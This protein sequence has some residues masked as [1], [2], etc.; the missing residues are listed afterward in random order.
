MKLLMK[1]IMVFKS[2]N[3]IKISFVNEIL[4]LV[5]KEWK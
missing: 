1:K 2:S 4:S 5:D 3:F